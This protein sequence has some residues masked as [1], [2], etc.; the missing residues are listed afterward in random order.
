MR[1]PVYFVDSAL[2]AVRLG[3]E[4]TEKLFS[5]RPIQVVADV[6][7]GQRSDSRADDL[8]KEA[9]GRTLGSFNRE[10]AQPAAVKT[11]GNYSSDSLE[12]VHANCLT[13]FFHQVE[14]RAFATSSV[15]VSNFDARTEWTPSQ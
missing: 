6:V 4:S 2:M 5:G 3:D 11:L 10:V 15:V 14:P 9:T 13:S 8:E 7:Q 12:S 1:P